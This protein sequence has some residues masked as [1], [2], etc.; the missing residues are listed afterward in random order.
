MSKIGLDVCERAD[1]RGELGD[2]PPEEDDSTMRHVFCNARSADLDYE[3]LEGP[4]REAFRP[5]EDAGHALFA[6]QRRMHT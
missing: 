5:P 3:D 4:T 1:P 6:G 2:A